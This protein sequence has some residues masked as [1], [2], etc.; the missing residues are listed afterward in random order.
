MNPRCDALIVT[1]FD[2]RFQHFFDQWITAHLEPGR[3]DRVA[4]AGGV[5]NWEVVSHQVE[6]ARRLH[7]VSR[8]VLVN[9]ED[10]MAYG[11]EGT[12]KRHRLDLKLARERLLEQYPELTVELYYARLDG[13]L[14][15]VE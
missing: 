15:P 4:L 11:E 12:P 7:G 9:H 8:V 3:Y 14:E 5:L 10:C 1:C 6:L 13:P 2:F